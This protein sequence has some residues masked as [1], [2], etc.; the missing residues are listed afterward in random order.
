[1]SQITLRYLNNCNTYLFDHSQPEFKLAGHLSIRI[2]YLGISVLAS[3]A[4]SGNKLASCAVSNGS[5]LVD[6]RTLRTSL[7]VSGLWNFD[8]WLVYP[9]VL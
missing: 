3:S 7:I 8:K 5:N 2:I 9:S 6:M 4:F 1:M